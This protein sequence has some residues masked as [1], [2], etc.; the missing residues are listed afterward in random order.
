MIHWIRNTFIIA[1]AVFLLSSCHEVLFQEPQPVGVKNETKVPKKLRGVWIDDGDTIIIN[2]EGYL[3]IRNTTNE[4]KLKPDDTLQRYEFI[5]KD[6]Y[7]YIKDGPDVSYGKI[8][9][10]NDSVLT[11]NVRRIEQIMLDNNNV[12][13]KAGEYYILNMRDDRYDQWWQPCLITINSEK[14]IIFK[15]IDYSDLKLI[16]SRNVL[17]DEDEVTYINS[18]LSEEE[19]ID[20]I[21]KGFFSDTI[22]VFRTKDKIK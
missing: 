18:R 9:E 7:L 16:D 17:F 1:S 6:G 15:G 3:K 12:L 10:S 8:T 22:T 14:D 5:E 19:M 4:Y 13:R 2:K 20:L 11:V 21:E